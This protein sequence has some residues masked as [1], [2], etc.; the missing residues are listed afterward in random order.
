MNTIIAGG[1]GGVTCCY[2][3]NIMMRERHKYCPHDLIAACDGIIA[4]LVSITAVCNNCYPYEALII[5]IVSCPVYVSFAMLLKKFSIDDPLNAQALHTSCGIW[6]LLAAGLF[7]NNK[8]VF[9][10]DISEE[11]AVF[12]GY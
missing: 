7:D 1:A 8:G 5:G 12:V 3:K 10:S 2:L 6:G 9:H 4:G 11:T